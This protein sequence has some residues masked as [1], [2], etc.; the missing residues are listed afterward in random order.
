MGHFFF[1]SNKSA[2]GGTRLAVCIL[3]LAALLAPFAVRGQSSDAAGSTLQGLVVD[4]RGHPLAG[5]TVSLQVEDGG[6]T[7]S[8]HTNADGS[9][10]FSSLH[11]GVYV[12]RAMLAGYRDATLGHCVVEEKSTKKVDLTL[13]SS[14]SS[15]I[16]TS[17]AGKPE[18]FD[19]PA[20]TVAGVTDTTNLGGH[21]SDTILRSKESLARETVALSKEPAPSTPSAA[22][23]QKNLRDAAERTP[24]SFEANHRYGAVLADSGKSGEA[25]PYLERASRL[26]P[27]DY[28]N[29]FELARAYAATGKY[30]DARSTAQ[31]LLKESDRTARDQAGIHHLLGD[32]E[33]KAG[34]PLQ[35]VRDYQRAAELDPS[36][37]NLFDWGAELLLHHAA[38]PAIEVFSKG[39]RLHPGSMRILVG[40]GVSFYARGSYDQAAQRL[41]EAS[42]LNPQD[43]SPYLF[44]GKM[45]SAGI[46]GAEVTQ[47]PCLAEKLKRFASLQP[48]NALANYYYAIDL[49]KRR[50]GPS[51]T[52]TEE[53][54]ESLLEKAVRLDPRLADGYLQLGILRSDRKDFSQAI[55]AY[56]QAIAASPGMEEAHYR[57]AQ[58]YRRTGDKVKAQQELQLY[59]QLSSKKQ[60]ELDRQ[61]HE[62]QQFVYTLR[63]EQ[64]PR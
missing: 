18:F 36:E 54:V 39:N 56:Q 29:S 14:N 48:D 33:E 34:N 51:D 47:S 50:Q 19:E 55:S 45:Q 53:Q 31:S 5:V 40:L 24:D 4:S 52:R 60:Q 44:I 32:I 8:T 10:R 13:D 64:Q 23:T 9:Y 25:I 1:A 27:A 12:L 26:K 43:P 7:L 37:P 58:L 6:Q 62:I 59:Q 17:A 63:T 41:C 3:G 61:R 42:D 35:A 2:C 22:S 28:D 57:L 49:L 20:F 30:E 11:E 16:Q 46:Q 38:D 15:A 21:G